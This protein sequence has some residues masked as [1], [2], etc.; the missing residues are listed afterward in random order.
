[1]KRLMNFPT[2]PGDD[3]LNWVIPK[4]QHGGGIDVIGVRL[5]GQN[6]HWLATTTDFEAAFT[7]GDQILVA[8]MQSRMDVNVLSGQV[9]CLDD[10]TIE[11]LAVE[12]VKNHKA[13]ADMLMESIFVFAKQAGLIENAFGY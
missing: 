10:F 4:E 2:L 1:M 5:M 13:H 12:G 7:A 6:E 3:D 11:Y 8:P 9:M